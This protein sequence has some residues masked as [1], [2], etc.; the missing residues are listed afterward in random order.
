MKLNLLN[1]ST[2][3]FPKL[4]KMMQNN[5]N[6]SLTDDE[7]FASHPQP[8]LLSC[9]Y[10]HVYQVEPRPDPHVTEQMMQKLADESI[11][12]EDTHQEEDG[13]SSQ[14]EMRALLDKYNQIYNSHVEDDVSECMFSEEEMQAGSD[15]LDQ[16]NKEALE[17]IKLNALL[18]EYFQSSNTIYDTELEVYLP[19]LS[20]PDSEIPVTYE[21]LMQWHQKEENKKSLDNMY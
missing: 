2:S 12:Y 8:S 10:N 5:N 3:L 14:E 19:V 11:K 18:E 1:K 16:I 13:M 9:V 21:G 4:L 6:H 7:F 20:E 17:Q 15:R